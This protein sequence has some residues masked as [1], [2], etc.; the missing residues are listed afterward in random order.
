MCSRDFTFQQF[1]VTPQDWAF[2]EKKV[3]DRLEQFYEKYSD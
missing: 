3:W 1:D 2:W